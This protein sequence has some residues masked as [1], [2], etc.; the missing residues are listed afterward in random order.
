VSR[1]LYLLVPCVQ[2]YTRYWHE[3]AESARKGTP[4]DAAGADAAKT[5]KILAEAE[6]AELDL[7][8]DRAELVPVE[9]AAAQLVAV[10]ERLR[11]S[12][13]NAPGKFAPRMVGKQTIAEAQLGLEAVIADIMTALAE[14]CADPEIAAV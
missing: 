5:R 13:L 11:A 3:K 8:R 12:L 4:L 9:D 1:G 2:A 10:L 7:A 14:V 6:R